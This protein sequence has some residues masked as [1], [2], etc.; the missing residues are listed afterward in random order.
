MPG[1]FTAEPLTATTPRPCHR[2]HKPAGT[3]DRMSFE[4]TARH[5]PSVLFYR[6][7]AQKPARF[8]F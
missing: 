5:L 8:Y 2:K 7:P 4:P 1:D 6:L 3:R